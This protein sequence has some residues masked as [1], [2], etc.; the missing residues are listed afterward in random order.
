MEAVC[1]LKL[2]GY[3]TESDSDQ[4]VHLKDT[5]VHA[6]ILCVIVVLSNNTFVLT[7]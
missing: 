6:A 4:L 1:L 7:Y 5:D 2:L 3:V